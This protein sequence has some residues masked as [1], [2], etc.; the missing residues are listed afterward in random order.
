MCAF[1]GVFVCV[2]AWY[3]RVCVWVCVWVC[4]WVCV[5]MWVCLFVCVDAERKTKITNQDQQRDQFSTGPLLATVVIKK[6]LVIPVDG[7][8]SGP[9]RLNIWGQ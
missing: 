9:R 2:R 5:F 4:L 6:K 8:P 3:V 7:L 1:V